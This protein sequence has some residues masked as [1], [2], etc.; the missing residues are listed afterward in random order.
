MNH[1]QTAGL[2][3]LIEIGNSVVIKSKRLSVGLTDQRGRVLGRMKTIRNRE[4]HYAK[5][6]PDGG[7][8][9]NEFYN[10]RQNDLLKRYAKVLQKY[11][12]IEKMFLM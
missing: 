2:I 8:T 4:Q 11:K 5:D 7:R 9:E 10:A 12:R 6:G 3:L 1:F